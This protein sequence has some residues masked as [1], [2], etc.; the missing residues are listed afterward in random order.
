MFDTETLR[1]GKHMG[2]TWN[3]VRQTNTN[4]GESR[5][6][7]TFYDDRFRK[8]GKYYIGNFP[9]LASAQ[10]A[11]LLAIKERCKQLSEPI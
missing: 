8:H 9:T 11:A 5:I 4:T 2:F 10:R 6:S 7:Y 1:T 3:V